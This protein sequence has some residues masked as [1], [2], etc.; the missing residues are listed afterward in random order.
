[1]R[2]RRMADGSFLR[3]QLLHF[4]LGLFALFYRYREIISMIF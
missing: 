4:V 3:F 1:M 2:V